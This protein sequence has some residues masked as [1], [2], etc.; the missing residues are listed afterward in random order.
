MILI[1]KLI[2]T[3]LT[4]L[5]PGILLSGCKK[6]PDDKTGYLKTHRKRVIRKWSGETN[7][8]IGSPLYQKLSVEF[9]PDGKFVFISQNGY[10]SKNTG[11]MS[12]LPADTLQGDWKFDDEENAIALISE[13]TREV[14]FCFIR[15]LTT[16][17]LSWERS[18]NR[19]SIGEKFY[20]K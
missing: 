11:A 4:L 20:A 15:S 3:I 9:K 5:L 6:Y 8:S 7:G 18:R 1:P 10:M 14:Q 19:M 12:Y 13:D 17:H 2:K 16:Q